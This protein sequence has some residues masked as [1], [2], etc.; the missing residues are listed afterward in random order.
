MDFCFMES[1]GAPK[2][3]GKATGLTITCCSTGAI[4][5]SALPGK[6]LGTFLVG[7]VIQILGAWGYADVVLWTDQ[8][9]AITAVVNEVAKRRNHRTLHR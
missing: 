4:A 1:S 6:A 5:S 3:D 2:G 9:E 8:E 7:L